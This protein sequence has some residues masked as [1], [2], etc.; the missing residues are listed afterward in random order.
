[1]KFKDLK[2]DYKQMLDSFEK[3][4]KIRREQK[5]IIYEQSKEISH[6]KKQ[7]KRTQAKLKKLKEI[8]AKERS[9]SRF[10][11]SQKSHRSDVSAN[12]ARGR[13]KSATKTLKTP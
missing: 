5:Q 2:V 4:E 3:S 8:T 11:Q 10:S 6:M 1:M 12:S 7:L 13:S 9:L